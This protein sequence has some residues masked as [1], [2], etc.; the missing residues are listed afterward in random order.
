MIQDLFRTLVPVNM[1]VNVGEYLDYENCKCKEKLANKPV[2]ECSRNIDENE[3]IYNGTLNNYGNVCNSCIIYIILWVI[4]FVMSIRI[5]SAFNYFHW[6]L[7][8][9]DNNTTSINTNT[10]T[11]IFQTYQW[12]ILSKFT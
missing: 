10:G 2:E 4:Y 3:I 12:V 11:I 9:S 8:R 7:K 5:N 6:Y 1:N